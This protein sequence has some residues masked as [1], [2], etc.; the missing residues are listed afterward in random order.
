[1]IY[2]LH[3]HKGGG[4]TFI[5]LAKKNGEKFYPE[6]GN[7]NPMENGRIIPFWNYEGQEHYDFLLNGD[8]TFIANEGGLGKE[9]L[10][11]PSIKYVAVIRNPM[12]ILLSNTRHDDRSSKTKV[13]YSDPS[14]IRKTPYYK[15]PLLAYFS[16]NRNLDWDTA[17][18][19]AKD[20]NALI[21]LDN[22]RE[23]MKKMFGVAGWHN[24]DTDRHRTGTRVNS[25]AEQDLPPHIVKILKK[26]L[27]R[28]LDFYHELRKM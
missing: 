7:A 10:I 25:R 20:F 22:Y 24:L 3:V 12:D 5:N 28:D 15:S 8:Y 6:N 14:W 27:E 18:S 16:K 23:E 1:M 13:D 11:H 9:H 21:F 17:M 26:Q 2:F 19:R 4:S